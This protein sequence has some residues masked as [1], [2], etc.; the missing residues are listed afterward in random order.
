V[1]EGLQTKVDTLEEAKKDMLAWQKKLIGYLLAYF[2]VLYLFAA[3]VAYFRFFYHPEWQDFTS[4]AI[5]W[6]PFLVAPIM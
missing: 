4:Q 5:L 6:I 2:S 3:G 1:L